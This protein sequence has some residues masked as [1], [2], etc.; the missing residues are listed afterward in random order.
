AREHLAREKDTPP[1][2]ILVDKTLV[3]IAQAAPTSLI[4]LS[5]VEGMSPTQMR[6]YG[7]VMLDAVSAGIRAKTP[8][9]PPPDPPA[10]PFVVE[11]YTAL[12]EWRKAR[13]L[14]RGVESDVII[15]KDALWTLAERAPDSLD[16]MDEVRGLGPWRLGAYG[17][18][19]LEVIRRYRR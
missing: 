11:R 13:A 2:K 6:R 4:D 12:R 14:E 1:F 17:A 3:A 10:D 5:Q 8:T 18:E 16:D 19:I 7:R 9:P 15:S